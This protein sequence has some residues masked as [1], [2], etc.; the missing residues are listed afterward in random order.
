M[1]R[2]KA[3]GNYIAAQCINLH[4]YQNEMSRLFLS[5]APQA[6][7]QVILWQV[8]CNLELIVAGVRLVTP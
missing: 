2:A 3:L 5:L 4:V 1:P 8:E 6:I 7:I